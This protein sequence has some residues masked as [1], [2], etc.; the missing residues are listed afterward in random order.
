MS[1][2]ILVAA[3]ILIDS[4]ILD[5]DCDPYQGFLWYLLCSIAEILSLCLI[6]FTSVFVFFSVNFLLH[7]LLRLLFDIVLC[8][9]LLQT[10]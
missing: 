2:K 6:L 1:I 9:V 5:P 8:T 4:E 7:L 3:V 10:L